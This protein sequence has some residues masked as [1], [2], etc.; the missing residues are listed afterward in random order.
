MEKTRPP[1][2]ACLAFWAA[3]SST[4][5]AE[6]PLVSYHRDLVP[7]FKRSC[8]GCH[9]PGKLKGELD[10]TTYTAFKKGGKHGESFKAGDPKGSRVMEEIGGEEPSMPK[11]GDPLTK[12]EVALIE[13]WILEGAKDD[14]PAL[15]NSIFSKDK[16]PVYPK[17]PVI[18]ALAYSPDGKSLPVSGYHEIL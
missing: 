10:L 6:E 5:R 15:P 9:H 7:I 16:P 4:C 12:E 18:S 1:I 11:E 8:T 3:L 17:P 14:T 13:R 2:L